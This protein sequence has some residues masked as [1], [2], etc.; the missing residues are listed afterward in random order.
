MPGENL[1]RDEA[2]E[3]A[4]HLKVATYEVALELPEGGPHFLSRTRVRF[5]SA[6][7][8]SDTFID[9]IAAHVE[10]V[11]LNGRALAVPEV[12][13]PAR[14]RLPGLAAEN[15]LLVEAAC[16]YMNTGE[17]LHHF[18]DPADGGVYVYSDFE[19][20]N[21][22]RAFAV[23]DQPDLK[24]SFSF[25]V[26]APAAWRVISNTDPVACEPVDGRPDVR[27]WRF[28]ATPPLPSYITAIVAGTWHQE[29]DTVES[30]DGRSI[31]LGLACRA[32][33]AAY[34]EPDA[35]FALTRNGLAHFERAF[36]RPYPFTKYDQ[37]FVPQF[38]IGG[39]ENAGAVTL[40]ERGIFRSRQPDHEHEGRAE[41]MLHELA[42][43]WFGDLVTMAWWDDL[44]LNESFATYAGNTALAET[45][46]WS[47]WTSFACDSK[48]WALAAD[49]LPT[50]HPIVADV[51]DIDAA[52][53]NFDGI[54][55][56]KGAAILRQLVAW[57][58]VGS[59]RTGVQHY[60]E[61]H[62]WGN[63]RLDDF[64]SALEETSGRDLRA[65]SRDWLEEAGVNTLRLEVRPEAGESIGRAAVS[66]DAP[67]GHPRLRPH[68]LS[69][70]LYD[71]TG[72]ALIRSERVAL[73]VVGA[74]T[75]V[76]QLAGRSRPALL[77]PNDDDGAYAKVRLDARS[78]A[79]VADQLGRIRD[80]L[81]RSQAWAAMWDLTRDGEVPASRFVDLVLRHL[82]AESHSSVR[83]FVIDALTTALQHYVAPERQAAAGVRAAEGLL[84]LAR[85]AEAG[86]DAQLELVNGFAA[87]ARSP[88]Q[89][90]VVEAVLEGREMWPG[91][92]IDVDLRW[93]LL[94]ALAAG[95]RA[96]AARIAAEL[97][98]DATD[99][100]RR[101]AATATAATPT[102]EAKAAA[103]SALVETDT[104][105][106][107]I[108]AAVIAG[109]IR[110]HDPVLL[111]PYVDPYFAALEG[112][113]ASRTPTTARRLTVGLFPFQLADQAILDRVDR[114]IAEL[115]TERGAL[116]RLL[117]EQRDRMARAI[118]AQDRDRLA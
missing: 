79:V 97:A 33:L 50:T 2:R 26:V 86:S 18:V 70:G 56:E 27:S 6:R 14:I 78:Q 106:N 11:V 43:M 64:L 67:P 48:T 94:I 59:F 93:A 91:L 98:R 85:A 44:W 35:L 113:W 107:A 42:H 89:L 9:L 114:T 7:P 28:P 24:A 108:Q 17:G 75:E 77:L 111:A 45:T 58:G 83:R 109:C 22:R 76:P 29:R 39:M 61:G 57:V 105:P 65:W 81:A 101:N 38:N 41:V 87:L 99:D 46:R 40:T 62:A 54:T 3:R 84:A 20:T 66:Q 52:A 72:G 90:D 15:E 8:G 102:A 13:E 103:W 51:P 36:G 32:S 55:Y 19:P 31:P 16:P 30:V 10:R 95:G 96:G 1:T 21:A 118:R 112:I 82:A 110:V 104:L 53:V 116:R 37:I 5:T 74:R 12:V 92:E 88:G 34:L 60:F 73:D 49:Q 68:R 23:F 69:I 117:I 100:G 25:T 47:P 80:P 63:A 4:S 71:P 115:P